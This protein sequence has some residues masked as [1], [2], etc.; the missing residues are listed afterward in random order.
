MTPRGE[1]ATRNG[2]DIDR[3]LKL[4]DTIADR[5]LESHESGR[6]HLAGAS[7]ILSPMFHNMPAVGTYL[8]V[9]PPSD[10]P[11]FVSDGLRDFQR[12][13]LPDIKP[14]FELDS[15]GGWLGQHGGLFFGKM[16]FDNVP[17]FEI[18][19]GNNPRGEVTEDPHRNH[20]TTPHLSQDLRD[21]EQKTGKKARDL[22][23][24]TWI[25]VFPHAAL[26]DFFFAYEN[27]LFRG[28]YPYLSFTGK[29]SNGFGPDLLRSFPERPD[30]HI[31]K[32]WDM[33]QGQKS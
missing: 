28:R 6:I 1:Q 4:H 8:L 18:Y 24:E 16:R 25:R 13:I 31:L 27:G 30:E 9:A 5:L 32:W 3:A 12:S 7:P 26:A 14:D 21:L 15:G 23:K 11:I 20:T 17:G 2:F 33:I 29:L 22:V 10:N 19:Y